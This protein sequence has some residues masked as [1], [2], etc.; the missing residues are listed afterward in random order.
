VFAPVPRTRRR[1]PEG[2]RKGRQHASWTRTSPKSAARCTNASGCTY[3]N[4]GL[5]VVNLAFLAAWSNRQPHGHSRAVERGTLPPLVRGVAA[6]LMQT[7]VPSIKVTGL[8]DIVMTATPAGGA[9][10]QQ[11]PGNR[12]RARA[13]R[14]LNAEC[15]LRNPVKHVRRRDV[16]SRKGVGSAPTEA[17]GDLSSRR[18]L[19]GTSSLPKLSAVDETG[20]ARRLP[21]HCPP[22]SSFVS[23]NIRKRRPC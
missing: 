17:F 14:P 4:V 2:A 6:V 15:P 16:G 7:Q 18:G 9:L 12:A 23:L 22:P 3:L 11:E 8:P 20:I 21:L 19:R 10:P 1:A 13:G 5:G